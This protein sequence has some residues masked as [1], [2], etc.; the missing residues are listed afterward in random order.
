MLRFVVG[1]AAQSLLGLLVVTFVVF[2]AARLTGDPTVL[3]LSE[4]ATREDAA[5]LRAHLGLDKPLAA[6]YGLFLSQALQGD[7]G[8]STRYRRPVTDV[9]ASR[10]PAS[11]QLGS[12]AIVVSLLIALPIGVYSAVNRGTLL[13]VAGRMFAV[14]GQSL[15]LF[16]LGLILMLILAVW[17]GVLP[18]AGR[19]GLAS[20]ILPA[21][22]MGW[23]TTP[24]I[25]RLTRSAML[26]VLESEYVKLARIK[27]LPEWRVIWKHALKNALLPVVTFSVLLFAEMIAGAIVTETVFAWPGV[28]QLLISSVNNRDFPMVQGTVLL[29][30]A[31]FILGNFAV[32]VLY[33]YLNPRIKY[34]R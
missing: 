23:A 32:D 15:P 9:L 7:L 28:G 12:V 17:L 16:W 14:L 22:T 5:R 21:M 26:E 27:G 30:S 4:M 33:A 29:L 19:G 2:Y 11:L 13:D 25:M 10:F 1:R 8:E 20:L 18:A 6:Q 34:G 31:L 24:A 3:M